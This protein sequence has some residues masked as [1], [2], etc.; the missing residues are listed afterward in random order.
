M[1]QP[2]IV[3]EG[4]VVH[5][6]GAYWYRTGDHGN[7]AQQVEILKVIRL[8]TGIDDLTPGRLTLVPRLPAGLTEV[9]VEAYPVLDG[10]DQHSQVSYRLERRQDGLVFVCHRCWTNPVHVRLGPFPADARLRTTPQPTRTVRSGT[11]QW[12][13]FDL[14]AE[15]QK[16]HVECAVM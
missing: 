7:T 12:A 8:I 6:S 9:N 13:W 15:A 11:G 2:W 3:P 4:T 14:F 10:T 16:C 5:P 1:L